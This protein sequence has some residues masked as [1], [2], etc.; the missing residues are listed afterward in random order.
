M[1]FLGGGGAMSFFRKLFGGGEK[2]AASTPPAVMVDYKGYRITP[3]PMADGGQFRVAGS[4]S[5]TFGDQVKTHRFIRADVFADRD[6]AVEATLRKAQ[7]IIDQS[8][9]AIF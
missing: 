6:A 4:I 1:T 3:A 5:K 8:G 9:D 7:L 2:P